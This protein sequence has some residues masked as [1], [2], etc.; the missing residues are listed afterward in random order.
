MPFKQTIEVGAVGFALR[1]YRVAESGFPGVVAL[2]FGSAG[3]ADVA[4]AR[5]RLSRGL[6]HGRVQLGFV[7]VDH[8][9]VH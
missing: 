1:T 5:Q 8:V 3:N 2:A 6:G 4:P 7:L 9:S